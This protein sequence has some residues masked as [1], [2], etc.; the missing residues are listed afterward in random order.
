MYID[1]TDAFVMNQIYW[2]GVWV[3]KRFSQILCVCVVMLPFALYLNRSNM[4][5][6]GWFR[7]GKWVNEQKKKKE[8]MDVIKI[9]RYIFV[10]I[11]TIALYLYL[12]GAHAHLKQ[13]KRCGKFT[14]WLRFAT[15]DRKVHVHTY[16]HTWC[17]INQKV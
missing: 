1:A 3:S 10:K 16:T 5:K 13:S 6:T 17:I 4:F 7:L 14:K 9:L 12:S 15:H 8:E 2:F 11:D